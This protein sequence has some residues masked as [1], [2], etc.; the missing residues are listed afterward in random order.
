MT[1]PNNGKVLST[2]S[3]KEIF[4]TVNE[5]FISLLFFAIQ[6][7][8]KYWILSFL[9]SVVLTPTLTTS[10]GKKSGISFQKEFFSHYAGLSLLSFSF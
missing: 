8:S 3:P 6:T 1:V 7:P 2:P 4:L 9:P 10:P 5:E